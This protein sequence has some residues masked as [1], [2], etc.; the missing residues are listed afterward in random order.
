MKNKFYHSVVKKIKNKLPISYPVYVRRVQMPQDSFGDCWFDG[1]NELFF[2]RIDKTLSQMWAVN[3]FCHEY[4]HA[5][6]WNKEQEDDHGP[7]WGKAYSKVYR[8]LVEYLN[9]CNS[10][11][12]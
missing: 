6:T 8:I 11:N 3:I 9:H 1:D 12:E 10:L 4:A 7:S 5:L 2:I